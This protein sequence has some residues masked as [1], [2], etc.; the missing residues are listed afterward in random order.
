MTISLVN[1]YKQLLSTIPK[2]SFYSSAGQVLPFRGNAPYELRISTGAATQQYGVFI[3]EVL[4]TLVTTNV[5][6][7]AL[8]N[9]KLNKGRN[10][11]R[12]VN[13]TTQEQTLAYITTRDYATILAAEAEVME[14]I[15]TGVEQVLLDSRLDTSSI[16]L[17]EQVF[18]KTV[19]T[20][21]D[22]SFDLDT[23]RELLVELRTAYRYWGGTTDGIARAVRAFTQVSPLIYPVG[24]GP[25]WILGK[26]IIAPKSGMQRTL[27]S[28]SVLTNIN[29]GAADVS[30]S[31]F[32]GDVGVGAGSLKMYAGSPRTIT[33]T[34]PGGYEGTPVEIDADGDYVVYAADLMDHVLSMPGPFNQ[35][36]AN[37]ILDL[38]IDGKG[39]ISITLSI[40]A[41][42]TAATNAT[43]INA[44]LNADLRY[45]A[46]YASVASAYDIHVSGTPMIRL[47]SPAP[48]DAG[49]SIKIIPNVRGAAQTLFNIPVMR[50]G[51]L[52]DIAIG[53]SSIILS[54]S[55]DMTAWPSATADN[56]LKIVVGGTT[57]HP[58]GAP[59]A[60]AT[61]STAELLT[62]TAINTGT[63]TL[64]LESATTI[65]H[66]ANELVCIQGSWPYTRRTTTETQ[67]IVVTVDDYASLPAGP[68]TDAVT[69]LGTGVPDNW[70]VTTNAGAAVTPTAA[71]HHIYFD[72]DRDL[73]FDLNAD[74]MVTIPV[75]DEILKYKGYAANFIVWG[76][77]DDPSRAA[78]H[79]TVASIDLSFDN[80]TSYSSTAP[81]ISGVAVNAENRPQEYLVNSVI[82][83]DA[84]RTWMRVKLSASGVGNFTIH[85]VRVMIENTHGGLYLGS[86]TTPRNESKIKQGNFMFVWCPDELTAYENAS[87]GL[88]NVTQVDPG[89][90]DKIAPA[91]AWLEKFD[92]TEYSG[93]SAVN[94]KGVFTEGDI[95]G[96][97]MTNLD[98]VLRTPPRFSHMVPSII[99]ETTEIVQ[100][101]SGTFLSTLTIES[102]E[103]MSTSY[104]LADGVPLTQDEW[105]YNSAT[106]IEILISP[107]PLIEYSFTYQALIQFESSTIDAGAGFADYVWFADYHTWI[108]PEIESIDTLI[109]TGVQFNSVGIS[110]LPERSTQD[111][112]TATL[113]EDAGLTRRI[114][115]NSQWNFLDASRIRLDL[116]ALNPIGVYEFKYMS[117]NNHPSMDASV[118]VEIKSAA[119]PAGLAA[120]TYAEIG[121]N[122]VIDGSLRY[123]Q[124]RVT[125]SN[126]RDLR[127]AKVQSMLVKG[128]NMFGTSGTVPI[129]RP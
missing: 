7:I 89:H 11:I 119:A 113:T 97:T 69:I 8:L 125:L 108:R 71:P 111:K 30:I 72:V 55:T 58:V 41:A 122:Q 66:K 28:N 118:V 96:G 18:G 129:L 34:A 90:I 62:V 99:S 83:H 84:T 92:V 79:S 68:T 43:T 109:R 98:L 128:L 81:T 26:D 100:F 80:Q 4:V 126:I 101:D 27:Y 17:I 45:G 1:R 86:G 127:D 35:T 15:D 87:L 29:A 42:I 106:E 51:I 53:V 5:N 21:N 102:D 50:G 40:G 12:L 117:E 31:T 94:V 95:L 123:H 13:S 64:T 77:I 49:S 114:I 6:G 25:I 116:T 60:A 103:D 63:K 2:G 59:N 120:A 78:T 82:P 70:I 56:P 16:G 10:D 65:A 57:F 124:M 52:A 38:D 20:G 9:V 23:Y 107:S 14:T 76:R 110:T 36:A 112:S 73:P 67:G 61:I 75:P 32:N 19:Q 104:L 121:H 3:N 33:W 115:S 24:F 91:E 22:F 54:A 37:N 93:G 48:T 44:A 47:F 46:G 88:T 74:G 85:K 105:Q 39:I